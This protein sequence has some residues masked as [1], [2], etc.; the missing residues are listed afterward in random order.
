MQGKKLYEEILGIEGPWE[1][2]G[3]ELEGDTVLVRVG[4]TRGRRLTCPECSTPSPGYDTRKRSWRHLDTCQFKTMVEADVPRVKCSTHGVVQVAV[5]WAEPGSGFTAL[6]E[7]LIIE[8]LKE[9]STLA[10]ARIMDLTWD[11]VD[12]VMQRAVKRGLERREDLAPRRIG[13]DETS[14]QKRHEYV[15]VVIDQET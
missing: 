9:A 12:G 4:V 13:I 5:P 11:Q 2:K 15:T 6:M 1:V 14:F 8:W 3:F 7:A 10:V